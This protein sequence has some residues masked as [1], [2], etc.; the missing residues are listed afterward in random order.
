MGLSLK[1]RKVIDIGSAYGGFVIQC[2]KEG[3]IA[4]GIEIEPNLHELALE[5][6]KRE[7]G[8]IALERGNVLDRSVLPGEKF[9][10]LII[11][12]VFE[13]VF[14]VESFFGRIAALSDKKA[15][16]YFAIPNGESYHSIN[17]E[18][19]KFLFAL[20]LLEPGSWGSVVGD[21]NIYYRPLDLYRYYFY[22]AGYRYLYV[23]VDFA[24]AEKARA[25]VS[26]KFAEIAEK[27]EQDPFDNP[28]LNA[29]AREKF[30][31][32]RQKLDHDLKRDDPMIVHLKYEQYFW[33]G[34]GSKRKIRSPGLFLI[35]ESY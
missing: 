2:A 22:K 9:D 15:T 25:R 6:A 19:H 12:D 1:G 33:I 14:D 24:E 23:K 8:H 4:Q 29:R 7:E 16:V 27:L 34:Y 18:G 5:N 26:A 3:A 31:L 17:R 32:L 13:H 28:V 21:F 10:L 20:T 30:E 11:N 35:P